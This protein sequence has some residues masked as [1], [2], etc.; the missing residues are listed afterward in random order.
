MNRGYKLDGGKPRPDLYPPEAI[1]EASK[2]LAFGA[3]KYT[4]RNWERGMKW[5]RLYAALQRH[6]LAWQSGENNDPETGLSHLAH[7]NCCIAMLQGSQARGIGEDDR[8]IPPASPRSKARRG[9]R[10]NR[11]MAGTPGPRRGAGLFFRG[12]VAS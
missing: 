8:S 3:D 9:P 7:A 4:E 6:L 5:G 11:H 2:V 10:R 12:Q 1:L